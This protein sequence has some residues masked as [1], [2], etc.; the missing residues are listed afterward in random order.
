MR[1]IIKWVK[2]FLSRHFSG[3]K[4]KRRAA[5]AE[6]E[7]WVYTRRKNNAKWGVAYSV[8]DGEEL[9]EASIR[10]IRP[11]V[12]YVIVVWQRVSWYGTPARDSLLPLL[13]ELRGKGLIDELI[14]YQPDL[15]LK[16]VKNETNKRNVGLRAARKAGV[17]HY[18]C[19]DTDEFYLPEDL[20]ASKEYIL[21]NSITHSFCALLMYG[22]VPTKLI[23]EQRCCCQYFTRITCLSKHC[24]EKNAIALVDPTRKIS[25]TP[26]W[27]GGSRCFFMHNVR[28]HHFTYIRKDMKGKVANSTNRGSATKTVDYCS[29]VDSS[30]IATVEDYFAI[31]DCMK[32][33]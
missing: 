26:W 27:M 7:E 6:M 31:E 11:Y 10:T 23:M 20:L 14:E 22:E 15:K 33:W 19:M 18:M 1:D 29:G 32:N 24:N 9:L 13:E 12:D 21:R 28:M 30:K 25:L 4:D 5:K 3:S 2:L 17:T 16:A 8:Y